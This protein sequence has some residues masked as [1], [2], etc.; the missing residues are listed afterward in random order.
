[1]EIQPKA[2]FF[3]GSWKMKVI[4]VTIAFPRIAPF[5]LFSSFLGSPLYCT[6]RANNQ[7]LLAGVLIAAKVK[8]G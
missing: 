4:I 7:M 2:F 6:N 1:M 5:S 3:F 8:S